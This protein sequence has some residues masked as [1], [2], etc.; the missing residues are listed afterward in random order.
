MYNKSILNNGLKIISHRMPA[1]QSVSLGIWI[2]VGGRYEN[3]KNKGIAHFLEH[4]L[5]KGTK[6]YSCRNLKSLLKVS[7]VLLM[8]LPR[9]S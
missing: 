6:K 7:V 4:L 2:K 1:R 3:S 8:V 5:F 9:K